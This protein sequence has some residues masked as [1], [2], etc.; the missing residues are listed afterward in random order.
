M[1]DALGNIGSFI[2]GIGVAL[3]VAYLAVQVRLSG[4][5]A[6]AA[7]AQAVMQSMS[8]YLRSVAESPQLA[9]VIRKAY[10]NLEAL[11]DSEATQFM[12]WTFAYF[13]LIELAHHHYRL[14]GIPDSFWK[15]QVR[16]LSAL[17]TTPA[18]ARFWAMRQHFFSDDFRKLIDGFDPAACATAG[19]E[20]MKMYQSESDA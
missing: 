5:A 10:A 8:E 16:H 9:G 6:K 4:K 12:F 2:G 18:V 11:E 14:G 15:G 1:L 17:M 19:K 3:T 13:R 20:F 7:A